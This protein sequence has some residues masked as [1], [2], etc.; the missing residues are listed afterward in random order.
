MVS[1]I[2]KLI[3]LLAVLFAVFS[4]ILY[5]G[6]PIPLGFLNSRLE[7][8][9]G[10]LLG[11]EVRIEAP[12]QLTVSLHPSIKFSAVSIANPENW[13]KDSYFIKADQG[14]GQIDLVSLLQG[15][16]RIH[17]LELEGVDLRLVTRADHAVN[18]RFASG[19]RA[20]DAGSSGHELSGLDILHL[21]DIRFSYVDE[22]GD[23]E[24]ILTVASAYGQGA[25]GQPLN[26]SVDGT[27]GGYPYSLEITGGALQ[28]LLKGEAPWHLK[29][30][31]L[32]FGDIA[33]NVSGA[34][35]RGAEDGSAAMDIALAG[36]SI[37]KIV[38]IFGINMPE[39]G[40]FSLAARIGVRPGMVYATHLDLNAFNRSS[41]GFFVLSLQGQRP[42]LSGSVTIPALDT[43]SFSR[44]KAGIT[45]KANIT[46][47]NKEPNDRLPWEVLK[48][49]DADLHLMVEGVKVDPIQVQHLRT[50]LSLVN[51][52]LILPFS[53]LVTNS[54][55]SGR[56]S[57]FTAEEIPEIHLDFNSSSINLS[58]IFSSYEGPQHYS[59]QFGAMA[60]NGRTQGH[61]AKALAS[62]LDLGIEIGPTLLSTGSGPMLTT[63]ILKFEQQPG[64]PFSLSGKGEYLGRPLDLSLSMGRSADNLNREQMPLTLQLDACDTAL[65]LGAA[66]HTASPDTVAE[67]D[68][69]INGKGLCGLLDPVEAFL[70]QTAE[71]AANGTGRLGSD[72][73]SLE[74]NRARLGDI[75]LDGALEQKVDRQGAPH[76]SA[77]VHSTGIDL[78]PLLQ[79]EQNETANHDDRPTEPKSNAGIGIKNRNNN[80]VADQRQ[81]LAKIESILAMELL[82]QKHFLARDAVLD[83]HVEKLETGRGAVSE[84]LLTVNIEDGKIK[85][86]PFQ[87][88]LAGQL[89]N[90]S[91]DI[92]LISDLPVI[93]LELTKTDFN[94]QDLFHEFQL[95]NAP[96]ITADNIALD[97]E[98]KGRTIKDMVQQSSSG[99]II[100]G[101]HWRIPRRLSEPLEIDIGQAAYSRS[102]SF[103]AQFFLAGAIN[104]V[105]LRIEMTEDGLLAK[106]TTKPL[107]VKVKA[108]LADAD[109]SIDGKVI[110]NLQRRNS[111]HLN[112]FLTG[113]RMSSLNQLLGVDLPPLGPYAIGGALNTEGDR[114]H[115]HDLKL[116]IGQSNLNG[117]VVITGTP[118]KTAKA[119]Y[120]L[121][122]KTRLRAESIQLDDFQFAD[123]SPFA[124]GQHTDTSIVEEKAQTA[125]QEPEGYKE[126]LN[127]LLSPKLAAMF[128]GSLDVEVGEVLSGKDKLGAGQLRAQLANGRYS[129][130]RLHL[131]IPGGAIHIQGALKPESSYLDA[132]LAVQIEHL[133]YGILIRRANPDSD[134][135]G[136]MNLSFD[137]NSTAESY[138]GLKERLNGHLRIGLVPEGLLAGAVDLW[139]V[140]ILAAALPQLLKGS[141]SEVNCLA[142]NFN[143]NDGIMRP[144]V[145]MLDTSKM[146]V[147]GK[148]EINLKTNAI[149]FHLKPT[150]KSP[151]FF[152]LAT[153]ISVSGTLRNPQIRV[154]AGSVLR[155]VFRMVTSIATV[156][157]QMLFTSNMQPDG[158]SACKT[159]MNW[160]SEKDPRN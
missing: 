71:F 147:L 129:L 154:T 79:R 153:P 52:D 109:L 91:T 105:P 74:L 108:R 54:P 17:N 64:K 132:R 20:A 53:G 159:A 96:D 127:N 106:G 119:E 28:A 152:S 136:E 21:R 133:D 90:G 118:K 100:R 23:K 94:L 46:D 56:L 45:D 5:L 156:P 41:K 27:F 37:Q 97:F 66:L 33:L 98:L 36:S 16:I 130:N 81:L 85:K 83:L 72:G 112:T 101:G 104:S 58:P 26:L 11:R 22:L 92:D 55:V 75:T 122:L 25:P 103:P 67:F 30:G 142:G 68:F 137:V 39:I 77:R 6:V 61:T 76:L 32:A 126:K 19:N 4:A 113:E 155:S 73:W 141:K 60:L 15:D 140:N 111:L 117:E 3:I 31:K 99:V 107:S 62:N 143:L 128:E 125:S 51:G 42:T 8:V 89:F 146:R 10:R 70:G 88:Q 44:F 80:G 134:I 35:S 160:V 151:Q 138:A 110:R 78:T 14:R 158:Q 116:Q 57:V 50:T 114:V 18:Y 12:V 84:I 115:F 2:K 148:G 29:N 123:W 144:E 135:Q 157:F 34:V 86:S 40:E 82:P 49:L 13:K 121:N 43:A 102:P 139:A 38:G 145:F 120:P 95:G 131:D 47:A 59:G 7:S 124:R 9:A 69:S 150:P 24:Y 149:N 63:K 65:L 93:K 1:R 87:A 48:V